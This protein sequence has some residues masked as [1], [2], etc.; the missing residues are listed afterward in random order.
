MGDAKIELDPTLRDLIAEDVGD[1]EHELL[2][3]ALGMGYEASRLRSILYY[4][5]LTID[6]VEQSGTIDVALLSD[7]PRWTVEFY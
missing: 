6:G 3:W 2:E 5:A 7:E 1:V 4:R